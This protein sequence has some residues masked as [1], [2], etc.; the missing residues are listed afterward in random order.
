MEH[1]V[2]F[3]ISVD[4]N[5]IKQRIENNVERE[6]IKNITRDIKDAISN[7]YYYRNEKEALRN[8]VAERIDVFITNEK[9]TILK[10]A[11]EILAD[12]LFRSKK[13]KEL[14]AQF[15]VQE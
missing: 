5:A 13:G 1:I 4:D 14:L 3:A 2:Q 12:R 9:E 10:M 15:E 7:G 6:V 11:S 8:M